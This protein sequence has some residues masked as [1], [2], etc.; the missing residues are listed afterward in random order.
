[1]IEYFVKVDKD[2]GGHAVWKRVN[3]HAIVDVATYPTEAQAQQI[4]DVLNQ[5]ARDEKLWCVG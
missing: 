2:R 3:G 4:V 1:V 5:H